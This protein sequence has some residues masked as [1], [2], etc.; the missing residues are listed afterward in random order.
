[1]NSPWSKA[2]W[3]KWHDVWFA[4]EKP[5]V[6]KAGNNWA[7]AGETKE[8]RVI[9][10]DTCL[11]WGMD[12]WKFV[13]LFSQFLSMSDSFHCIGLA[14]ILLRVFW[15]AYG[16]TPKKLFGQPSSNKKNLAVSYSILRRSQVVICQTAREYL[17]YFLKEKFCNYSQMH[18]CITSNWRWVHLQEARFSAMLTHVVRSC[19]FFTADTVLPVLLTELTLSTSLQLEQKWHVRQVYIYDHIYGLPWGLNGREST[20]NAGA[21]GDVGS[22]PG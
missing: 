10:V 18:L 14:K 20:C 21:V 15:S 19:Q 3:N 11:S 7:G 9:G 6:E 1:M 17:K 12:L 2:L 8:A 4:P 5:T 13:R 16:K 22:I